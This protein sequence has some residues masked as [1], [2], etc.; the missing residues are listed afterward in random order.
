MVRI[1]ARTT[2]PHSQTPATCRSSRRCPLRPCAGRR[3]RRHPAGGGGWSTW[4]LPRDSGE[5]GP[6]GCWLVS[7]SG[8]PPAAARSC[9]RRCISRWCRHARPSSRRPIHRCRAGERRRR[10]ALERRALERRRDC[11]EVDPAP[12][13]W[14]RRFPPPADPCPRR[15]PFLPRRRSPSRRRRWAALLLPLQSTARCSTRARPRWRE[16]LVSPRTARL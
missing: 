9:W 1:A 11:R 4:S 3:R 16:P 13:R 12:G 2:R 8:S 15:R 14:S 7:C 6:C 5:A 10:R